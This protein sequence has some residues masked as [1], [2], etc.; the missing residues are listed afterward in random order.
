M[1]NGVLKS[2]GASASDI[3]LAFLF[4]SG[5]MGALGAVGGIILGWLI[6]RMAS[7]VAKT[8]MENEGVEAVELFAMPLWLIALAMTFGIL[9]AVVAGY[10]PARRAARI[11]PVTALRSD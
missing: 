6:S 5:V 8:I 9:V 1:V 2:L 3:K 7:M 11:D 10:L 4:E